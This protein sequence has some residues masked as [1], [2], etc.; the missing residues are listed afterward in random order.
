MNQVK[1]GAALNYIIIA[2]N[3]ITGLLYT[4]FMLKCLGQNEYGL[5]SLVASV[6]AYLTLL[7]FGFG[8][9]IVRY[10]AK[11]RATGTARDEWQLYGMFLT[12]YSVLGLLVTAAGFILF[13]NTDSMFDRT[14]TADELHQARVMMALMVANLAVT[15]PFSV[16]GSII[17]AYE[18]FVFQRVLSISRIL[19]ST[20]VLIAV[21]MMGYKAIAMVVVQTAFSFGTLLAN[22]LYCRYRL[23]IKILFNSFNWP[24]MKEVLIFS[25]WNFLSAIVDRVYWGTG[26]FILGIY[27]G[28]AS[29]AI[30][31]LGITLMNLYMSM[32]TSLTSVLLP[33]ITVMT[34][35]PGHDRE[36]SDL[37]IRTGRLQFCVLAL[38][39]SGFTVFGRQFIAIWAGNDYAATYTISLIFFSALICPLIQ[40]VGITIL[41]ARGQQKFRSLTYLAIAAVSL[42]FQILVTPRYGA[43]GCA[44]VI[45][46]TLFLG[47][48]L[49]MN[50]Y[51]ATRQ[52]LDVVRFWLEIGRMSIVP[53]ALSIVGYYIVNHFNISSWWSIGAAILVFTTAYLPLFYLFSMNKYERDT[54]IVPC[55]ALVDR[56]IKK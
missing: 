16:F 44:A 33:R 5:Y 55:K 25:W 23:R 1:A 29:V 30:F 7:D 6:I 10:T 15:F 54:I 12:A 21:L 32:S 20:A 39:L 36:I 27:C 31:S 46:L 43:I 3:T 40:N 35:E 41:L 24:L 19:L 2:L 28:T 9:A 48:W 47:Q 49:V 26:Q 52:H 37:F 22:Y 34:T 51:Y 56:I 18:R 17:T 53:V 4:P 42:V 13:A 11:I 8:S 45:G 38:I 50:I 14:M